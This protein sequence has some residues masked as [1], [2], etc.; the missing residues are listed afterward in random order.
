MALAG[1]TV[2][3]ADPAIGDTRLVSAL[4]RVAREPLLHFLLIGA[5]IFAVADLRGG[6]DDQ[7]RI[8]VDRARVTQLTRTYAQQFGGAP[9]PAMLRTLIANDID[10][11][12][13]YREGLATGLDP[14]AEAIR[15]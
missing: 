14:G 12:I 9:S 3:L 10:E 5:A 6:S 2:R 15:H 7:H 8:V 13:L 11:E 4:R 1:D